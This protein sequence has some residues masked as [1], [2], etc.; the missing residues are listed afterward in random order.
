M[1]TVDSEPARIAAGTSSTGIWSNQR[2]NSNNRRLLA[3]LSSA[4]SSR[5][6]VLQPPRR[7]VQTHL[8]RCVWTTRRGGCR[9]GT[10]ELAALL[11]SASNLR[12]LELN[13][14]FDQIPVEEVPAAI[15]AGSLSTVFMEY[16][17]RPF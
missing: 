1:N 12:L 3:D 17:R 5:V 6:P 7:V 10:R 9:T 14:W 2:F 4:A 11:R 16:R 13:L 8:A 15:R